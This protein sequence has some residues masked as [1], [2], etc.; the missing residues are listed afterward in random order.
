MSEKLAL[1]T[2]GSRGIGRACA[3][4]LAEAGYDVVINYAGNVDAA[5]KTVEDIKAFGVQGEAYQFDVASL[6][7]TVDALKSELMCEV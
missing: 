7:A 6:E 2:G 5:N 1:V 4:K 3:L